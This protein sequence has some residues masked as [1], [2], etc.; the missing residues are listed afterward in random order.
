MGASGWRPPNLEDVFTLQ[1]LSLFVQLI[2]ADFKKMSCKRVAKARGV[3]CL[4]YTI[5]M[6][7]HDTINTNPVA[8]GLIKRALFYFSFF[9]KLH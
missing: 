1:Q 2:I 9:D 8:G 5:T 3:L 4:A 6:C 7:L